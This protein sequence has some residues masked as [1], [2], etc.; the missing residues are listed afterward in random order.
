MPTGLPNHVAWWV[1][2]DH[3]PS[4]AEG[5]ARIDAPAETGPTS[6][7]S[8]LGL[9]FDHRGRPAV[10]DRAAVRAKITANAG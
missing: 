8:D 6:D 10:I 2:G 4:F 1:A 5:A 3:R 9:P 7:A